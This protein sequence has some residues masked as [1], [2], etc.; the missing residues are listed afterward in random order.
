MSRFTSRD[1]MVSV[2][3]EDAVELMAGPKGCFKGPVTGCTNVTNK[4]L[5]PELSTPDDLALLQ[6]QLTLAQL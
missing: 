3:P 1:L 2:L 6:E 4:K 5:H